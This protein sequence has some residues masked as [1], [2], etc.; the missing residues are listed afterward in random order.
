MQY[1]YIYIYMYVYIVVCE[2][3][4]TPLDCLSIE[5]MYTSRK[6]NTCKVLNARKKPVLGPWLARV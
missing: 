1:T 5:Y 6:L 3:Y 4:V 2:P